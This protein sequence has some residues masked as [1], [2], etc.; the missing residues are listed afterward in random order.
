[1]LS[2]NRVRRT[3]FQPPVYLLTGGGFF[4]TI[5]TV[6]PKMIGKWLN[7]AQVT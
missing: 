2:K 7:A 1:M 3:A 5:I 4:G 6:I